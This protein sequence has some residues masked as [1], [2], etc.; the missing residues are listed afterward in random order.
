V[1]NYRYVARWPDGTLRKGKLSFGSKDDG[2]T[3]VLRKP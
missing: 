2:K 1:G 3:I